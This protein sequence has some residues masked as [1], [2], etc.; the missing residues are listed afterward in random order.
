MGHDRYVLVA[1]IDIDGVGDKHVLALAL[2]ATENAAV[3]KA[4]LAGLIERGLR[5]D[6]ARLF[7]VDGAKALSRA[8]R[9]TFGDFALIERCQVHKGRNIIDKSIMDKYPR[10]SRG[11]SFGAAQSGLPVWPRPG[12]FSYS[13]QCLTNKPE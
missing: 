13:A 6:I 10:Q 11:F 5:A 9:D 4:L 12:L 1:A 7:I 3:V 8:V 2:G